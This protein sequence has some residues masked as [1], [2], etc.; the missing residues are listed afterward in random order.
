[1]DHIERNIERLEREMRE[2]KNKPPKRCCICL[3]PL[4]D[5]SVPGWDLGNNAYPLTT[6]EGARCCNRCDREFVIPARILRL[7]NTSK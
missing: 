2:D 3:G 1:M 7:Q 4:S 5:G 6:T